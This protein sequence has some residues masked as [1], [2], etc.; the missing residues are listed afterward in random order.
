MK[1]L[2]VY[3]EMILLEFLWLK[4]E[5]FISFF[6]NF[7]YQLSCLIRCPA[8]CLT[9]LHSALLPTV[10][11]VLL[12]VTIFHHPVASAL[13][14]NYTCSLVLTWPLVFPLALSM[15]F[16]TCLKHCFVSCPSSWLAYFFTFFLSSP[17]IC[18]F[19]FIVFRIFLIRYLP[20]HKKSDCYIFKR[21]NIK[22]DLKI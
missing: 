22:N 16:A 8:F 21:S 1:L 20:F 14:H 15:A 4:K 9:N 11:L 5:H 17:V 10:P 12:L 13:P 6:V 2:Q 7:L 19:T 18:L 3:V